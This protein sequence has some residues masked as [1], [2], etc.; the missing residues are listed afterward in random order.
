[1]RKQF[2]TLIVLCG[3]SFSLSAQDTTFRLYKGKPNLMADFNLGY[4]SSGFCGV[5]TTTVMLKRT[6]GIA[7][8]FAGADRKAADLPDDYR[9]GGWFGS[10]S[11]PKD[12]DVYWALQVVKPVTI[13]ANKTFLMLHA[14]P[15]L[16]RHTSQ[17]FTPDSGG[18]GGLNFGS[19]YDVTEENR[20]SFG[21]SAEA[22]L[23]TFTS[24]KMGVSFSAFGNLNTRKSLVGCG[25]GI[26]VD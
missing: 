26:V 25:V 5:Q 9:G 23:L 6:F 11:K 16:S 24:K 18:F 8:S 2:L 7:F 21:L 4:S 1:M 3:C 17:I 10:N 14:G 19:N 12:G 15:S 13:K 22:K 20:F